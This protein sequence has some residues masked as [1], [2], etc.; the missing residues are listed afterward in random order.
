MDPVWLGP[1]LSEEIIKNKDFQK[2]T[3]S[4]VADIVSTRLEVASLV[5][6]MRGAL[7]SKDAEH[8]ELGMRFFTSILH[9]L[10]N[11]FL[12]AAQVKFI[13]AFYT[14]HGESSK[15][16][17]DDDEIPDDEELEEIFGGSDFSDVDPTYVPDEDDQLITLDDLKR[18]NSKSFPYDSP[19]NKSRSLSSSPV[20]EDSP[21][22]LDNLKR[23]ISKAFP[24]QSSLPTDSTMSSPVVDV[25][26]LP[27][28]KVSLE[29]ESIACW[30]LEK[31]LSKV[32][33]ATRVLRRWR[34]PTPGAWSRNIAKKRRAE[35]LPY[36]TAKQLRPAKVPKPTDC[37]KCRFDCNTSFCEEA[38]A[39]LCRHY[40]S[41]DY[42]E[43]KAFILANIEIQPTKRVLVIRNSLKKARQ[44]SKKCFFPDDQQKKQVFQKFFTKTLAISDS[45][46]KEAIQKRDEI[47][48]YTKDDNRGRHAPPNKI[49]DLSHKAVKNH[50]ESFPTMDPHYIRSTSKRKYLDKNLSI[51][52]MYNA[53]VAEQT[54]DTP[55]ETIENEDENQQ[56]REKE[57]AEIVSEM[58]YRRIFS[59][60]YNLSFYVPKKDQCITCT[61][62]EKASAENKEMIKELYDEHISRKEAASREK[63]NDKD[64]A[65]KE[66]NFSSVTFDLEAVLQI[67][68]GLVGP[69]YYCR[70]ICVY[71]LCIYE[72]ALPNEG[73]CFNWS[74]INGKRGSNEIGSVLYYYLLKCVPARVNE[75]SLFSDTCGGQNRN[76]YIC[77]ILLHAVRTIE[78]IHIIDHKFL[79]SGH[80]YMEV[81][82]MHSSIETAK[83][84]TSVF[85][86]CDYQTIFKNARKKQTVKVGTQKVVKNPYHAKEF[87]YDEFYDLKQLACGM[88]INNKKDSEGKTVKWLKI[89]RFRYMKSEPNKIFFNYDLS[90]NFSSMNMKDAKSTT[91][92]RRS[93]RS[94]R[95][96]QE[97]SVP[98]LKQLYEDRLPIS[99]AKKK[100][101]VKLCTTKVIPEELHGWYRSLASTADTD[102]RIPEPDVNEESEYSDD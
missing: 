49:S 58:T 45:V 13:S 22:T 21:I 62:Y 19:L 18:S 10:P 46:I 63:E 33:K 16:N 81:D 2:Y 80:S 6:N 70:K 95:S 71:N 87:K 47:G 4:I 56:Q 88:N 90:E 72:A 15:S 48:L 78:N 9:K 44:F 61:N 30:I 54:A 66:E 76:Q 26:K 52:K 74:E 79:E 37:S 27:V 12:N 101:L 39:K 55:T 43:K 25:E 86:M 35:G 69:L 1:Q 34:K 5:E 14:D 92:N 23:I 99:E 32:S 91:V 84:H 11:Q 82:S 41:L 3:Q 102:E 57:K 68:S 38:R 93:T 65:N 100:D 53:Y 31:I 73:Y 8:R 29:S 75:L 83:K 98:I 36:V 24:G 17:R 67:P 42:K 96:C 64:K 59:S 94:K 28:G 7:T 89:K 85:S 50:I 77:A 40:W 20:N 51:T 97:E 60:N